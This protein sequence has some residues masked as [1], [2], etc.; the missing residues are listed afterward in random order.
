MAEGETEAAEETEAA[1][2]EEVVGI[3]VPTEADAEKQ[4][5]GTKLEGEKPEEATSA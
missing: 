2:E 3:V 4:P 5:A 1:M